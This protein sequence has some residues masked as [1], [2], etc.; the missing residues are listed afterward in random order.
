MSVAAQASVKRSVEA[1]LDDAAV[2][3]LGGINVL[4]AARDARVRRVVLAST[5]GAIYGE[6]P[7]A[8]RAEE[9]WPLQPKSP[10]AAAKAALEHYA[11]VYSQSFGLET[12]VLR[13]AN[14]FGPRQDPS[15]EAG[16][17]AIFMAKLLQG[18]RLG[19]FA[20]RVAGD[21]GCVRDYVFVSDV[22]RANLMALDGRIAGTFNVASGQGL[23]TRA[24]AAA[25]GQALGIDPVIDALP[26]RPGDLE[27]S[28]LD[29]TALEQT[30]WRAEVSFER[31]VEL[32]ARWFACMQNA[33]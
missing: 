7:A 14:V 6:V 4:E 32:T 15:G 2:N 19:L 8:R 11:S 33:A 23:T 18:E 31:G 3:V 13:F 5:G 25:L 21:A 30:G 9:S 17:V 12:S 28:V 20:R 22:V 29:P 1:P 27:R 10:Y 24:V 16:V 26:P